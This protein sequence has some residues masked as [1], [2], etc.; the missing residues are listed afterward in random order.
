MKE[1]LTQNIG[2]K[3]LS[4]VMAAVVWLLIMNIADPMVTE[5]FTNIPVKI[6]NDD[7]L[8]SRGY[9][10]TIE[11]GERVNIRVRGKKKVVDELTD[12][13]FVA[14]ADF[15]TLNEMYMAT[16]SVECTAPTASEI[17]ITLRTE[18]MAI[19]REA[20]NTV[21]CPVSVMTIGTP[22]EGFAFTGCEPDA[23]TIYVTGSLS[24]TSEVAGVTVQVDI[25][26][27]SETYTDKYSV[28]AFDQAGNPIDSRRLSF[29]MEDVS[30]TVY[31]YPIR[32]I[33][34]EVHRM[35]S[36]ADGYYLADLKYSPSVIRIAA[37]GQTFG[38]LSSITVPLNVYNAETDIVT[39]V[40]ISDYLAQ[41]GCPDCVIVDGIESISIRASIARKTERYLEITES[42]IEVRN[43]SEGLSYS[44]HG[45]WESGVTVSGPEKEMAS[46]KP[47]DLNLYVDMYGCG[48]GTYTR[49]LYGT[50]NAELL[51]F[52]TI[53]IK[54]AASD[55]Q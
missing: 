35:G 32:E 34:V 40:G 47:A 8:T 9:G 53:V 46:L 26:G 4:L 29:S 20:Q 50:Y 22:A 21:S 14:T 49:K 5:N 31:I 6:I 42:D 2:L 25:S 7:V 23:E 54:L 10:Y 18:S 16:I 51:S 41:I 11:S 19:K 39:E 1:R 27:R 24:Q 12:A 28:I 44:L 52:G 38:R 45:L 55:G 15:L 37:D 17:E 13:D 48:E 36:P 43:V 33:P 3:I 30:C